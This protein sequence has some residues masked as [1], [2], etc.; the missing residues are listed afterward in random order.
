M[1]VPMLAQLQEF[2]VKLLPVLEPQFPHLFSGDGNGELLCR[3]RWEPAANDLQEKHVI[4][5]WLA[6][7]VNS[8]VDGCQWDLANSFLLSLWMCFDS[9]VPGQVDDSVFRYNTGRSLCSSSPI[10]LLPFSRVPFLERS[11]AEKQQCVSMRL[12]H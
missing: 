10:G 2:W 5:D 9:A 8:K 1:T 6:K 4:K 3:D 11:S 7:P 12:L